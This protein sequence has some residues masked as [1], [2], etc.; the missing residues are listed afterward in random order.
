MKWCFFIICTAFIYSLRDD[1]FI[2]FDPLDSAIM[3]LNGF[4]GPCNLF[5]S[6]NG[7]KGA[8][9]ALSKYENVITCKMNI[10]GSLWDQ[11]ILDSKLNSI[12]EILLYWT[13]IFN[14]NFGS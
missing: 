10:Y 8:N 2:S 6:L 1:I 7:L 3:Q 14:A 12:I 13:L 4:P 9:I 5:L 11:K